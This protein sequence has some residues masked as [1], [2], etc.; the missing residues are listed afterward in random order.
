[1]SHDTHQ[2]GSSDF[3]VVQ[4]FTNSPD[5]MFDISDTCLVTFVYIGVISLPILTTFHEY[6]SATFLKAV[7][8][9]I[10]MMNSMDLPPAR[11]DVGLILVN[12]Y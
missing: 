7:I 8:E 12:R 1:M 9:G 2:C 11:K 5:M 10:R 3:F 4:A 6:N